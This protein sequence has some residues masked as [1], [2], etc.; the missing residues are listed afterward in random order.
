[1]PLT[2]YL[3]AVH[4]SLYIL[5]FLIILIFSV[6]YLHDTWKIYESKKEKTRMDYIEFIVFS[7]FLL[8]TLQF[9][10]SILTGFIRNALAI[11]LILMIVWACGPDYYKSLKQ[12]KIGINFIIFIFIILTMI[13]PYFGIIS[14]E[15]LIRGN[16][17]SLNIKLELKDENPELLNHTLILVIHSN[18]KYYLVEKNESVPRDVTLYIIPDDQIKMITVKPVEKEQRMFYEFYKD[19]RLI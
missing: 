19:W 7:L 1:L 9:S 18:D 8:M 11:L 17:G 13:T 12:R 2:F 10:L 16:E 3:H 14:A 6:K 15:N 5:Y 4:W